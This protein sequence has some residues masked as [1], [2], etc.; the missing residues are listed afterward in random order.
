MPHIPARIV[1]DKATLSDWIS[2]Y[3]NEAGVTE[4]LLL[5]GGSAKPVGDYDSYTIN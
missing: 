4:A 3:Q 2:M 5:A 1:K